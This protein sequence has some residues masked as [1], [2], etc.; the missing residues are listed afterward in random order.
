MVIQVK[1]FEPNRSVFDQKTNNFGP[2]MLFKNVCINVHKM[3]HKIEPLL[4]VPF[5]T[6]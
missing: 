5:L 6:F 2:K 4:K 1:D 3:M